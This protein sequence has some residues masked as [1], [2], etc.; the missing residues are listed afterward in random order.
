MVIDCEDEVLLVVVDLV[1][2]KERERMSWF[3]LKEKKTMTSKVGR[4]EREV[5][6]HVHEHGTRYIHLLG[7]FQA[8]MRDES[9]YN[10]LMLRGRRYL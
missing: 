8:L 3:K 1:R 5:H 4:R 10:L 6:V 2:K 7:T 9:T